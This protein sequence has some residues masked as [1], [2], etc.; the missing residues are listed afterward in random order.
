MG[1][2]DS[3]QCPNVECPYKRSGK[4]GEYC[5]ECGTKYEKFGFTDSGGLSIEKDKF[6]R[7]KELIKEVGEEKALEILEKEESKAGRGEKY[8]CEDL[9]CTNTD[10]YKYKD[11]CPDCGEELKKL[12]SKEYDRIHDIKRNIMKNKKLVLFHDNL[13]DEEIRNRIF[14]DMA[15]LA[16]QETGTKW[17]SMGTLLSFN[18]T[19]QMIGAGFK[20]IIDQNKLIIRQ[21]ELLLRELQKLNN[22]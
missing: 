18:S 15:N 8:I 5:P 17:M 21:N 1:L 12:K 4:Q 7:K 9:Y 10:T 3:W 6:K 20:A 16:Y 22:K 11:N 13:T 14:E 2:L 19:E